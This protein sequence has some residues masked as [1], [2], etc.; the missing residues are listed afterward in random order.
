[1]GPVMGLSRDIDMYGTAEEVAF[2]PCEVSG[3]LD[4]SEL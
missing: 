1:M 3:V 4:Q 2:A